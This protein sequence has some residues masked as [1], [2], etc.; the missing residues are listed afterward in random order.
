MNLCN[1]C[2]TDLPSNSR[3]CLNCGSQIGVKRDV[4]Q[5]SPD[6]LIGRVKNIVQDASVRKIIV[7][8]DK[9]RIL[10]SIPVTWGTA[11]VV[12]TVALA[13]WLAALG[14][15]A[16]VVTKCTIEVEKTK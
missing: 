4:Y 6:N 8:D 2:N 9:G 14:V 1:E 11:G 10:I 3:F 7:K 5:V 12:A 15:I 16:G 13:P